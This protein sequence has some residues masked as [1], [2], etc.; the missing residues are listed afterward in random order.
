MANLAD[1]RGDGEVKVECEDGA[2]RF[3]VAAGTSGG[4]LRES[5]AVDVETLQA[6]LRI[7]ARDKEAGVL[8]RD[9]NGGDIVEG[10]G[11]VNDSHGTVGGRVLPFGAESQTRVGAIVTYEFVPENRRDLVERRG[12]RVAGPMIAL[13]ALEIWLNRSFTGGVGQTGCEAVSGSELVADLDGTP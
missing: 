6:I 5:G 13:S 11:Q 7:N 10:G 4:Q 9:D 12:R 3:S 1:D 2:V 8:N